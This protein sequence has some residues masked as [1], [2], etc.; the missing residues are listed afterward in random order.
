MLQENRTRLSARRGFLRLAA[1]FACFACAG[2]DQMTPKD[3]MATVL[4]QLCRSQRN[5]DVHDRAP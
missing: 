5:C 4:T 3:F 2:C 1:A